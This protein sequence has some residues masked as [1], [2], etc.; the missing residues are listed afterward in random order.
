MKMTK[1][2]QKTIPLN[3]DEA[4]A[5]AVKQCD[6]DVVAA[7]PITPQ[8]II[9]E[10]FSEYVANGEVDTEFV[11]VESEHTAMTCS[12]TAAATGARTFTATASAGLALMHEMLGVASGSRMPIV[13]SVVNRALSAPLNIHC[14]H[15]DS[16]AQRDL[17]W[18]QMYAENSQEAY[19][20]I[21]QAFKIAENLEVQLPIMVGIDGFVLSHTLENVTVLPDETV[22]KFVGIRQIP[23]VMNH[24]G[25]IVPFK[26]DPEKPLTLGPVALQ[27]YYFEHKRQQEEAMKK[28]LKV[29][30][31]VH[32][33]YAKQ[34]GRSYGNA[35]VEAYRLEDAEIV[36]VC[37]GST[38]GTIKTVVDDL[39]EKGIKAGLLRLRTFRP[40]PV[41]DII[42]NLSGKKAVAVMDR[43]SSFGGNGGPIFIEIRHALY[44]VSDSPKVV[45]YIYGL[46]GRDTRPIMIE[47]IYKDLQNIAKTGQIENKIQFVGLRE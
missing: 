42:S 8:T 5:Y 21:I 6:V 28:A 14:D 44:D 17:G 18:I 38:A 1:V 37:I 10:K 27:D 4:V 2:E 39:R 35:L 40:V 24:R 16:M 13:M 33:E 31:Q 11:C 9:V 7:Y 3:G 36:T 46:G 22:K 12:I 32:N 29:I 34:S 26:L 19:D 23:H 45:N 43:S 15:A 47:S 30:K 25:E 20:S 41:E